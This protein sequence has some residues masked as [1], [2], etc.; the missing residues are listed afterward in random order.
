MVTSLLTHMRLALCLLI[1][2]TNATTFLSAGNP[3]DV[4][5]IQLYSLHEGTLDNTR[6]RRRCTLQHKVSPTPRNMQIAKDV[7]ESSTQPSGGRSQ[8]PATTMTKA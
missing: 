3:G 1:P 6:R 8:S 4:V 5:V 7:V 2:M